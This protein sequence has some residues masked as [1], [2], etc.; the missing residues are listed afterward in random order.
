MKDKKNIWGEL[1]NQMEK[2]RENE[3]NFL[4]IESEF[5]EIRVKIKNLNFIDNFIHKKSIHNSDNLLG[6]FKRRDIL[7]NKLNS[8]YEK[9]K[10]NIDLKRKIKS[11]LIS[12]YTP[13]FEINPFEV[14][15]NLITCL[16]SSLET[17]ITR[18]KLIF[19]N[20]GRVDGEFNKFKNELETI[21]YNEL[22]QAFFGKLGMHAKEFIFNV[23]ANNLYDFLLDFSEVIPFPNISKSEDCWIINHFI[24][25]KN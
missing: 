10:E 22:K 11:M 23:P 25:N 24:F 13:H 3:N 4:Q 12:F 7:L 2:K 6:F 16:K 20:L 1:D 9:F 19:D 5:N 18:L 15:E 21:N 14:E 8:F 17:E